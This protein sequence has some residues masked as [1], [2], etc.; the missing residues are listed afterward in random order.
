MSQ[1]RPPY[2]DPATGVRHDASNAVQQGWLTK[3]S[4]WLKDWRR[5]FF[6]LK[7]SKLFF[8]KGEFSAPHGMIDLSN[9]MTVKS[10]ELKAGKKNAIEVSTKENTYYMYADTDK[11]KDDWIGAIGRSIGSSIL[12]LKVSWIII[13]L[14]TNVFCSSTFVIDIFIPFFYSSILLNIH[15]RRWQES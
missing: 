11:E 14:L 6:I 7:G 15:T 10:A 13:L 1:T 9:C 2:V 5:R 4:A 3:Q 12:L 8:A